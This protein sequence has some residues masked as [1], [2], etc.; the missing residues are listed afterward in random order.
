LLRI[1]LLTVVGIRR[2]ILSRIVHRLQRMLGD[3]DGTYCRLA[4]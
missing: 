4:S 3:A 1:E 2:L